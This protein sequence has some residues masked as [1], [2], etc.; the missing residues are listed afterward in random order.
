MMFLQNEVYKV[1]QSVIYHLY[2]VTVMN[3]FI[4]N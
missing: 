4:L 3:N 1:L 2:T